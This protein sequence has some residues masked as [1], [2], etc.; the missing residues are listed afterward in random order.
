MKTQCPTRMTPNSK[1]QKFLK[2]RGPDRLAGLVFRLMEITH[3]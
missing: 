2:I 1:S 3:E